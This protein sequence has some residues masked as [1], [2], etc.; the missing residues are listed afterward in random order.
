MFRLNR[1]LFLVLLLATR[2]TVAQEPTASSGTV[3]GDEEHTEGLLEDLRVGRR[4]ADDLVARY[5]AADGEERVILRIQIRRIGERLRDFVDSLVSHIAELEAAGIDPTGP[6]TEVVSLLDGV[7][8]FLR[9]DLSR[10]REQV[11]ALRAG[12]REL[13]ADELLGRE[14]DLNIVYQSVDQ[15]LESR[16]DIVDYRETLGL[17][18][19]GRGVQKASCS[20][21]SFLATKRVRLHSCEENKLWNGCES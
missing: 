2:P 15:V 11:E 21:R 1:L 10:M 20:R 4:E 17:D 18:V 16:L 6:R 12:R 3:A 19:G 13:A 14:Q 7:D 9:D 5:E 8:D